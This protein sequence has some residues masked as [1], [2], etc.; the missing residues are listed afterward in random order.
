[1]ITSE[2]LGLLKNPQAYVGGEINS[3][4]R[5][6]S[7]DDVNI[8]LVFP[9][10]YAIGMSHAGLKILYHLLNGMEGVHAQ[11]AF[12][13]D[14]EN[15]PLFRQH[16]VMLFSLE[17]R[18]AL[19]EFD[20]LGFSLMS[21]LNHTNVLLALEMSGLPLLSA[22][23]GEND[24]FIAAGGIAVANPEPLRAIIDLFAFGDGEGLFPDLVAV[25][26]RVRREKPGRVGALKE[27]DRV[28]GVYVPAL[29]PLKQSGVF[30]LP[31]MGGKRIRKRVC[32]DLDKVRAE[33]AEIVPDLRRDLQ[34]AE[35]GDRPWLPAELPFLPGQVV[36]RSVPHPL[37]QSRPWNSSKA[38]WPPRVMNR[39]PW[40]R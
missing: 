33:P 13:P 27:F 5:G 35:R 34:P 37:L 6:F 15:I 16:G 8:C 17:T 1:M 38:L 22:Q 19:K 18:T 7:R 9:D 3:C 25:L 39:S 12:L 30:L 31:D 20:L 24:P 36:L 21:E 14:P 10:T 32:P 11:R 29:Y 26:E 4:R 28:E 40:H 23:R 2:F